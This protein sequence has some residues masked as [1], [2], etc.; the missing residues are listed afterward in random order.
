M[1][2][3]RQKMKL[4]KQTTLALTACLFIASQAI[5]GEVTIPNTFSANTPAI[6]D[7]V[8]A[9]FTAVKT[10]IDINTFTISNL[11]IPNV[12]AF[13]FSGTNTR[14]SPET[15]PIFLK[16]LGSFTKK[17]DT[18][19]LVVTYSDFLTSND[20]TV[21]CAIIVYI[22]GVGSNGP[23]SQPLIHSSSSSATTLTAVGVFSGIAAG[24]HDVDLYFRGLGTGTCQENGGN[25]KQQVSI[26][27]MQ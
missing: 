22:D 8:N 25:Y 11:A 23:I 10:A 4:I 15:T 2:K 21:I 12:T 3:G 6:A 20:S 26:I 7:E 27:E 19:K 9:N 1:V 13:E 16:A 14:T 5:A 24:T 18:T 17:S